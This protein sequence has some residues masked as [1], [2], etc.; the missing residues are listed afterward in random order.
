MG[1]RQA[2]AKDLDIE[3]VWTE[4]V[5]SGP[6]QSSSVRESDKI[7]EFSEVCWNKVV[8]EGR[9]FCLG[10]SGEGQHRLLM[11]ITTS[12]GSAYDHAQ[13]F[14]KKNSITRDVFKRSGMFKKREHMHNKD[15]MMGLLDALDCRGLVEHSIKK[16]VLSHTWSIF[17]GTSKSNDDLKGHFQCYNAKQYH[18]LMYY[19]SEDNKIENRSTGQISAVERIMSFV[20]RLQEDTN[21]KGWHAVNDRIKEI[22]EEIIPQPMYTN[23]SKNKPTSEEEYIAKYEKPK[24]LENEMLQKYLKSGDEYYLTRWRQH[25]SI[26]YETYRDFPPY[27]L[28]MQDIIHRKNELD[29][30][31][32][33]N[34]VLYRQFLN[35]F[36]EFGSIQEQD[37]VRIFVEFLLHHHNESGLSFSPFFHP[38]VEFDKANIEST[39]NLVLNPKLASTILLACVFNLCMLYDKND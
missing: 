32:L 10:F 31:A 29:L 21:E 8:Q 6:V 5:P 38:G 23:T 22:S 13:P 1:S 19:E 14:L 28:N 11:C 4:E 39:S 12:C 20:V 25:T 33:N 37:T 18:M 9:D 26:R 16:G 27:T 3:D 15:K 2:A 24:Y 34:T 35:S 36:H 30:V 17:M 7:N